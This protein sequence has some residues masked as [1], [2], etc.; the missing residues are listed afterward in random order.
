MVDAEIKTSLASVD[1]ANTVTEIAF[2]GGSFT[3]IARDDMLYLLETAQRYIDSGDV[4]SIR[5]STRPDYIDSEILSVLSRFGVKTIE[6]GIQ[7][8]SD[9]VL[10]ASERGHSAACAEAACRAVL[11]AGFSLVGQMMVG[12]P[13][14]SA[15]SELYTAARLCALGVH[16]ARIYPTVVLYETELRRMTDLGTYKPL[17]VS[18]A[19]ERSCDILDEFVSHNIPV[20]RIGLCASDNLDAGGSF[21]AGGYHPALGELVESALFMKHIRTSL[22]EYKRSG[23][24]SAYIVIYCPRGAVSKVTGQKKCNM[25]QIQNEFNVKNIKIIETDTISGYNIKI[26]PA[27]YTTNIH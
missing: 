14:S 12:L 16:A 4:A 5:L 27:V 7:S 18:E 3:G 23:F 17:T 6:L 24:D 8:L 11:D 20:I 26:I 2:F 9:D 15:A 22:I 19:V 25:K 13:C 21:Y 10:S 1:K